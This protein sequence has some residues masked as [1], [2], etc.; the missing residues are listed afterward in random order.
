MSIFTQYY[1]LNFEFI[2][3]ILH[4]LLQTK[5]IPFF[6]GLNSKKSLPTE[7]LSV[8]LRNIAC[9]LDC[10]P[11]EAGLGPGAITWSGLILQ[12][13]TFFRRLI[14]LLTNIDDIT[15]LLK[16]M[17][18]ILKVSGIQQSKVKFRKLK[19]HNT[20]ILFFLYYNSINFIIL[21]YASI[22]LHAT[23]AY[24]HLE[25]NKYI[26][27]SSIFCVNESSS[28]LAVASRKLYREIVTNTIHVLKG[29]NML[30][31]VII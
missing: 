8:I 21:F 26:P 20:L 18:S 5:L 9:Y 12:F 28:R 16:I 3:S 29:K 31:K 7:Y 14:L 10:L 6:Q 11:L 13:D 24:L 30:I 15:P 2:N 17:I 25:Y 22:Y 27:I 23:F 19:H 4:I 1:R